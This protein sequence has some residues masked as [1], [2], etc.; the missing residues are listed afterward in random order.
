MRWPTGMAPHEAPVYARN[1]IVIPQAPA[2]VWRRLQ[3]AAAWPSWYRN[4]MWLRFAPGD[5]PDLAL[6]A[7]FTWRTF[8]VVVR[9][10][11]VVYR[12]YESLEWEAIAPGL[13]AYHGWH[14]SAEPGGTRVVTEETQRG[15]LPLVV[16]GALR[17]MLMAGHEL[18]VRGL[19]HM[20]V[21]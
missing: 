10:T 19:R 2:A 17:L 9:S 7:R 4:C 21:G 11:V 16:P 5:G 6:G 18:W 14:L 8:G 3:H 12:P 1:E 15:L 20:S 13:I